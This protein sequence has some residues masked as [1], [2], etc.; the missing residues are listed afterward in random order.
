MNT[1]TIPTVYTMSAWGSSDFKSC[2]ALLKRVEA[3]DPQ[4]TNLVILPIKTFGSAEL[5]R[6][7]AALP[8]NTYLVS[9]HASGHAVSPESLRRLGCAIMTNQRVVDVAVGSATM[10]DE[11]VCAL[12]EGLT[13][14]TTTTL[15]Q[16]P[17]E[18]MDF[19]YKGMSPLGFQAV[20]G[21]AAKSTKLW[22]LILSRNPDIAAWTTTSITTSDRTSTSFFPSVTDLDLSACGIGESFSAE[23]FPRLWSVELQ[24]ILRISHN[25]LGDQGVRPVFNAHLAK[26]YLSSCEIG[27]EFMEYIASRH[28]SIMPLTV[29]DLS[30]NQIS[31]TGAQFLSQCLYKKDDTQTEACLGCLVDLSLTSNPLDDDGVVGLIHG[32][33]RRYQQGL[34]PLRSVDLSETKCGVA[35][36]VATVRDGQLASLRLFNNNLGPKGFHA[37]AETLR[38]GHA[39]LKSLDLAGN[40][41]DEA[42]VVALLGALL[43]QEAG[44]E[45]V[46]QTLVVG[47]NQ[48]GEEVEAMAKKIQELWP[49]ID[50]ARDKIKR[51]NA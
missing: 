48:G 40:R 29:L 9:L 22:E 36:A 27:D 1:D 44:F 30:S 46:L 33:T 17:L 19:G 35:G 28:A 3:N 25:P 51:Q 47:G 7:S 23:F 43:V 39:T 37:L 4:L 14:L 21:L 34:S 24:R 20:I 8:K 16:N 10:G 50:I 12:C 5:D 13:T 26:L 11:G 41:A 49:S 32:L 6:V 38:G 45:S 2:D 15:L 18:R 42:S 31:C